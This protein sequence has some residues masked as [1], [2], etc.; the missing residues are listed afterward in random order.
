MPL[1]ARRA[2]SAT[3]RTLVY[4]RTNMYIRPPTSVP[5]PRIKAYRVAAGLGPFSGMGHSRHFD[6]LPMTSGLPPGSDIVNTG[7]EHRDHRRFCQKDETDAKDRS[8]RRTFGQLQRN[9]H[10]QVSFATSG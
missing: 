10:A 9:A 6:H 5:A 3:E 2:A 4:F 1:L 8:P 7:L